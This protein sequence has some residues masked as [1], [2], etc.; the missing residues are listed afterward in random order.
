MG[1]DPIDFLYLL[2]EMLLLLELLIDKLK[3]HAPVFLSA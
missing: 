1:S 3:D 2:V